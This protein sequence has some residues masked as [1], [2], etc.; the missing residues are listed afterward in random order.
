MLLQAYRGVS[1]EYPENT[2][3]ALLG[4]AEQGYRAVE[5]DVTGT[6]DGALVLLSD[7]PLDTLALPPVG[8]DYPLDLRTGERATAGQITYEE[9]LEWDF[10][11][12]RGRKHRN[13]GLCTLSEA[14]AFAKAEGLHLQI[15]PHDLLPSRWAKLLSM[16]KDRENVSL[17]FT[18][19]AELRQMHR[20]L[21]GVLLHYRGAYDAE[22]LAALT[23]IEGLTVWFDPEEAEETVCQVRMILPRAAI[24]VGPVTQYAQMRRWQLLG[25]SVVS[26]PG[27]IKNPM[28]QGVL[29]DMHVHSKNSHDAKTPVLDM[30]R[31]N[32]EAGVTVVNIADHCDLFLCDD[33]TD[34]DVYSNLRQAWRD[35]Q[36]ARTELGDRCKVLMGVELGEGIWYPK[37][38]EKVLE[39]VPYDCV[40]GS[41]H[42]VR[43]R[44]N[45][46]A[47]GLKLA[48]SQFPWQDMTEEEADEIFW[49]Y[50][51]DLLKTVRT[52]DMD[53]AAHL[54]VIPTYF[55][56]NREKPVD[57]HP[58]EPLIRQILEEIIHRG[59]ALEVNT[60][61]VESLGITRP[62]EWILELYREMGG[63]L[64]TLATDSHNS[65]R[66]RIGYEKVIPMLKRMGFRYTV[67]F[68]KRR[69]YQISL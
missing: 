19:A 27:Q 35:V 37:E 14:L 44:R 13:N 43:C 58:F 38:C 18:K 50:F 63:Y 24:A 62:E 4:A 23:E 49:L 22:D 25:V 66:I 29:P 34:V 33:D 45:E 12:L 47:Q 55:N 6:A 41:V 8:E 20:A 68:E 57:M 2:Y 48:Y 64:I 1:A 3:S 28:R 39:L 5:V 40:L 52:V 32:V 31:S 9:F 46:G 7:A 26:T 16:L 11:V 51:E 36:T 10:G 21:P 69:I 15:N 42:A 67:F 65:K 54:T 60:A 53:V 59:I 30:C 17:C 61:C 56:R